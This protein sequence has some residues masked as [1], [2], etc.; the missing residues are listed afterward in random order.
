MSPSR[1]QPPYPDRAREPIV[2][3]GAVREDDRVGDHEDDQEDDEDG[4]F[5]DE[6]DEAESSDEDEEVEATARASTPERPPHSSKLMG[7]T[8]LSLLSVEESGRTP[9]GL[10]NLGNSCFS[11]SIIQFLYACKPFREAILSGS[12]YD[13]LAPVTSELRKLFALLSQSDRPCIRATNFKEC[14]AD[15][16][17]SGEQQDA[18]EFL[19]YLLQELEKEGSLCYPKSVVVSKDILGGVFGGEMEQVTV[20]LTCNKK[21]YH[22][23]DEMDGSLEVVVPKTLGRRGNSLAKV[24]STSLRATVEGY[25][26]VSCKR[27][28]PEAQKT[29][30]IQEPPEHLIVSLMRFD[31]DTKTHASFKRSQPVKIPNKLELLS[32]DGRPLTYHAYGSVVH[33]GGSPLQGHYFVYCKDSHIAKND[34][35]SPWYKCN[36]ETVERVDDPDEPFAHHGNAA[37]YLVCYVLV[38][39]DD[40]DMEDE[41]DMSTDL[42]R[43]VARDNEKYNANLQSRAAPHMSPSKSPMQESSGGTPAPPSSLGDDLD[44]S[45]LPL[46]RSAAGGLFNRL[47]DRLSPQRRRAPQ[48]QPETLSPASQSPMPPAPLPS[49]SSTHTPSPSSPVS[50]RNLFSGGSG[51]DP[52]TTISLDHLPQHRQDLV[53]QVHEVLVGYCAK[54]PAEDELQYEVTEAQRQLRAQRDLHDGLQRAYDEKTAKYH[55]VNLEKDKLQVEISKLKA[56]VESRDRKLAGRNTTFTEMQGENRRLRDENRELRQNNSRLH[57]EIDRLNAAR[58][59]EAAPTQDQE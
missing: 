53:R 5:E 10:A 7:N 55:A 22:P 31:Y 6:E 19:K 49:P 13:R 40:D 1:H 17:K 47:L 38:D 25:D 44:D 59:N 12:E 20:C 34:S 14:L 27:K 9:P 21:S 46:P 26:C 18:H 4:S 48:T 2:S 58:E 52:T 50:G 15:T 32:A 51:E 42:Q 30:A 36:D 28:V 45:P 33:V 56:M 35:D 29:S 43:F 57:D 39:A 3:R 8:P 24:I 11:N 37:P 41:K 54:T 23:P 16:Y